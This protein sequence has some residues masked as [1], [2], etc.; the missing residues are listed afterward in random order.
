MTACQQCP[1]EFR[2]ARFN[3]PLSQRFKLRHLLYRLVAPSLRLHRYRNLSTR[4]LEKTLVKMD[5]DRCK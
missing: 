5:A 2:T 1:Q 3:I 4:M